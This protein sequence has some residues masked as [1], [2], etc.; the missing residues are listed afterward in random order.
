MLKSKMN[1]LIWEL[2]QVILK[3]IPKLSNKETL[4]QKVV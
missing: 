4:I 1:L 3:F 2:V